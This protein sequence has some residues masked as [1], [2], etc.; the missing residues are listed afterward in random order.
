MNKEGIAGIIIALLAG[1]GVGIAASGALQDILATIRAEIVQGEG[2][3]GNASLAGTISLDVGS[4]ATGT[5]YSFDD[6]SG[7]TR[8]YTGSGGNFTFTLSYN[9]T[10]FQYVRVEIE[11]SDGYDVEFYLD[12][13]NPTQTIALPGGYNLEVEIEVKEITVSPDAP[14]GPQEIQ[15]LITGP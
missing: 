3:G 4:L 11:L 14:L 2:Q 6:V 12:T 5:T 7:E 9:Q 13:N 15:V 10:A 8:L 1:I